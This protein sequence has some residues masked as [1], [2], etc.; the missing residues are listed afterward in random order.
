MRKV[1]NANGTSVTPD[2]ANR[3]KSFISEIDKTKGF[4]VYANQLDRTNHIEVNISV[5]DVTAEGVNIVLQ[6]VRE[7]NVT[8][9]SYIGASNVGIQI[10]DSSNIIVGAKIMVEKP[11]NNQTILNGG[12]S[13]NIFVTQLTEEQE[14]EARANLQRNLSSISSTGAG[15]ITTPDSSFYNTSC[16]VFQSINTMLEEGMLKKGGCCLGKCFL[17]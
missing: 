9:Y 6:N 2:A 14:Q 15:L 3:I 7:K 16:N 1:I 17:Q 13:N 8:D 5:N 12:Y 10:S 11:N 4:V